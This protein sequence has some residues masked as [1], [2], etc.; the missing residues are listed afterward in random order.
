MTPGRVGGMGGV[1]FGGMGRGAG[2]GFALHDRGH[3]FGRHR[4]GFAYGYAYDNC[5][6]YPYDLQP[7]CNYNY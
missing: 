3:H 1:H 2:R 4:H 7:Y 6:L 5:D